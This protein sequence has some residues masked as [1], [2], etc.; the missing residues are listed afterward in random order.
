MWKDEKTTK[1]TVG[2]KTK[3]FFFLQNT[4]N[5]D[6]P[7]VEKYRPKTIDDIQNQSH[8]MQLITECLK[9][10]QTMHF[11]F[12]GPP[13]CGKTSTIWAFCRNLYKGRRLKDYVLE[14]N[15]AYDKEEN[16]VEHRVRDFC[17][18]S[19]APFTSDEFGRV[20]YKFVVLD[21][22]DSLSAVTQ[23]ILRRFVEKYS[24]SIRFCFLCNYV[25]FLHSALTS[26]AILCHFHPIAE[27]ESL[28]QLQHICDNEEISIS[29]IEVLRKIYRHHTGDLR[30][31]TSTLQGVHLLFGSVTLTSL[32]LFEDDPPDTN[33]EEEET[34]NLCRCNLS[35][36]LHKMENMGDIL[37]VSATMVDHGICPRQ[38]LQRNIP[39]ILQWCSDILPTQPNWHISTFLSDFEL[40]CMTV[41]NSYLLFV[42]LLMTFWVHK[43][44]DKE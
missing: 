42:E 21:E 37:T 25:N 20:D 14:V 22:A 27:K 32:G 13:G 23:S 24:S 33:S 30:A 5:K 15:A 44:F 8:T 40:K 34:E 38:Y 35:V 16:F 41:N 28:S 4:M 12:Y 3:T 26:R 17:R 7:W 31:C 29:N 11:I 10:Q 9:K 19:A 39:V 6:I 18:K 36:L 2:K 1:E 43:R